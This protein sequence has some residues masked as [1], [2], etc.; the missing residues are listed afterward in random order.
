MKCEYCRP[1]RDDNED[2]IYTER[3][4][5]YGYFTQI[6][7]KDKEYRLYTN[8][9]FTKINYCPICGRKLVCEKVR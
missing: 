2:L 7:Y 9:A 5:D 6:R 1:V 4:D 8:N 3:S